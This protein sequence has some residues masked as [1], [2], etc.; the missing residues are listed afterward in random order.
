MRLIERYDQSDQAIVIQRM[1]WKA[2][3]SRNSS[4]HWQGFL[5]RL[6]TRDGLTGQGRDAEHPRQGVRIWK[7]IRYR[8]SLFQRGEVEV[9]SVERFVLSALLMIFFAGTC[10]LLYRAVASP[11]LKVWASF[12]LALGNTS[13]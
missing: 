13:F 5:A 4:L 2:D 3:N 6:V 7:S 12:R 8:A 10:S 9:A 1:T 11:I